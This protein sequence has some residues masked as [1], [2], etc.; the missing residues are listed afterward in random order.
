VNAEEKMKKELVEDKIEQKIIR[1][2]QGNHWQ[3]QKLE[4]LLSEGWS[5]KSSSNQSRG[6]SFGRT[7]C[8]GFIFLPLAL[9]GRKKDVTEYILERKVIKE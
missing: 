6:W 5:I 8:L 4:K 2:E 7:C 9:L 3:R 1:V